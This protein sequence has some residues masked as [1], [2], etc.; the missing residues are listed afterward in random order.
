MALFVAR[1]GIM[2][3]KWRHRRM[4]RRDVMWCNLPELACRDGGKPFG[5]TS[6]S[7]RRLIHLG[8][9]YATFVSL[10]WS[11]DFLGG[12]WILVTFVHT[13]VSVTECFVPTCVSV[14]ECFVHT[15]VTVMENLRCRLDST[16]AV[17]MEELWERFINCWRHTRCVNN[18]KCYWERYN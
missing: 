17:E 18:S 9:Q 12:F 10:F 6:T 2:N 14:M 15:C 1:P 7:V 11:P 4:F 3:W 5:L 16:D 13:C 8:P